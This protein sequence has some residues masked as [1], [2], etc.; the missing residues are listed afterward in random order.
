MKEL[1]KNAIAGIFYALL[2]IPTIVLD[3]LKSKGKLDPTWLILY[4]LI[5]FISIVT[6]SYFIWGYKIVADKTKNKILGISVKLTILFVV[7]LF[8]IKFLNSDPTNL[9]GAY[10]AFWIVTI[11]VGGILTLLSGIGIKRLSDKIGNLAKV[12]GILNII[13]GIS[14]ITVVFVFIDL[15]L[16]IPIMILEIVL[17]FIIADKL[18]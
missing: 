6:F 4:Y 17:M 18:K 5:S 16:T 2:F 13:A 8:P 1:K 9:T 7:L 14:A 10:K 3:Y 11:S 12:V 15:L